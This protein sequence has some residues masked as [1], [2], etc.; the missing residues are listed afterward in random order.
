MSARATTMT[1]TQLRVD[2]MRGPRVASII[3][4]LSMVALFGAIVV[5]M[6]MAALD[7]VTPGVGKV[8][9][10]RQIQIVQNLEGGIVAEILTREGD[11]VAAGQVLMRIDATVAGAS[12][13]EQ[14]EAYLPLLASV[15][16]LQ[17]EAEG[18]EPVYPPDLARA[19]PEIV[20]REG[21][22]YRARKTELD[23]V[24]SVLTQQRAQ[25]AQEVE[26]LQGRLRGARESYELVKKEYDLTAPLVKQGLVAQVELL[27]LERQLSDFTA[28]I[29]TANANI[30][31]ARAGMAEIDQ[32]MRE[33]RDNFRT[34]A[35]K[36]LADRRAKLASIQENM[37]A[38]R[39]RME[40]AELRS[41]VK[42]IVK[43]LHA[44]TVGGI[45]QPGQDVISIVPLEDSLL[46][47]AQVNPRDVAFLHPGQ[48]AKVKLTAYDFTVYGG[49]D[50]ELESISADTITDKQG[51]SFYLIRVRT[52]KNTLS[53]PNGESLPI[54]PG[55]IAQVDILTGKRTVLDYLVKPFIKA[56]YTA[57]RER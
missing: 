22:L 19:R 14:E 47:E 8:I 23:S 52:L 29:S 39:D 17:A 51:N 49:M 24:V 11:E 42:G 6:S 21:E 55:M 40:R 1:P 25:R 2:S 50:A 28:Q 16:R 10:S 35:L 18:R 15:A 53:R 26:E 12:F 37:T 5:W 33:R 54:I 57:L 34:E 41:P 38:R 27:R 3:M 20:Q 36:E 31:K 44:N 46:V 7:E 45:I 4:L 32:R 13:R 43:Q 30:P 56:R 48:P 9:P